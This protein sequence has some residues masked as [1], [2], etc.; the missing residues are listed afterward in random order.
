MTK[1]QTV[2]SVVSEPV[3][4]PLSSARQRLVQAYEHH[5]ATTAAFAKATTEHRRVENLIADTKPI[6]TKIAELEAEN[7]AFIENWAL[8][9][10]ST[11]PKL[12][13]TATEIDQLKAEL[14][15]AEVVAKGALAALARMSDELQACQQDSTRAIEGIRSA[16]DMV[17]LEIAGEYADMLGPLE[18]RAALL[19]VALKALQQ[20]LQFEGAR[21]RPIGNLANTVGTMIPRSPD[22]ALTSIEKLVGKWAALASRLFTD[23]QSTMEL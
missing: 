15:H 20:H 5:K 4:A 7:A 18:E 17:L 13:H 14:R 12:P 19:R 11:A 21:G 1:Q 2:L 3:S 10:S 6:E 16:A 22:P 8:S 23:Q 9:G